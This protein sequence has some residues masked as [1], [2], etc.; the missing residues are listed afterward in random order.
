VEPSGGP[1]DRCRP[2]VTRL[3]ED[4]TASQYRS[5]PRVYLGTSRRRFRRGFGSRRATSYRWGGNNSAKAMTDSDHAGRTR[6]S[7]PS[8]AVRRRRKALCEKCL[9]RSHSMSTGGNSPSRGRG[10]TEWLLP[11][12]PKVSLMCINTWK[13]VNVGRSSTFRVAVDAVKISY[14]GSAAKKS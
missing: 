10:R 1:Y 2:R 6:T 13:S 4:G 8:P 3:E 9:G 11:A 12:N 5:P 14:L 7:T